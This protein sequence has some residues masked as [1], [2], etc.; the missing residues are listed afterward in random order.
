MK[1]ISVKM[2]PSPVISVYFLR[3]GSSLILSNSRKESHLKRRL[4]LF[5]KLNI[6]SLS[7]VSKDCI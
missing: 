2:K 4:F 3:G 6:V 7:F 1:G 5:V